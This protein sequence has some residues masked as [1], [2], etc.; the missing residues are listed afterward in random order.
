MFVLKMIIMLT[1]LIIITI[2]FFLCIGCSLS[3]L[4][5]L[6]LVSLSFCV[7]NANHCRRFWWSGGGVVEVSA[8][9]LCGPHSSQLDDSIETASK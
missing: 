4:R 5:L 9:L 3:Y 8:F 1:V 6:G 2:S 7:K